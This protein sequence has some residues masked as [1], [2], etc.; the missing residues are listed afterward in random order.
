MGDTTE[1]RTADHTWNPWIGCDPTSEG[2]RHCYAAEM[3][4]LKKWTAD[5]RTVTRAKTTWRNPAKWHRQA[6]ARGETGMVFT[7]SLSDWFHPAADPWRNEAWG[8]VKQTPNLVWR[9][10][11]KRPELIM[12]RLPPDWGA[13]YPNVW[14]G[15]TVEMTK[16]LHRLDTIKSIPA[17]AHYAALEPLLED[18]TPD[19]RRPSGWHRLG[20]PRRRDGQRT[21]PHGTSVG[22][23]RA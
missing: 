1:I 14:L 21:P 11:T 2:C 5:F 12:H 9:I 15:V 7:C 10:T 3:H 19:P 23:E 4:R 22:E 20:R 16:H 6:A 8:V 18:L 13:G 17:V